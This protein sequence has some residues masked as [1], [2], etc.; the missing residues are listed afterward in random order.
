MNYDGVE[1]GEDGMWHAGE[2]D[3]DLM[4]MCSW[5]HERVHQLMDRDRGWAGLSRRDATLAI[6]RTIQRRVLVEAVR[7]TTEV[8]E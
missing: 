6:I 7:L 8:T 3:E 4:V 5:C 2:A 1:Q